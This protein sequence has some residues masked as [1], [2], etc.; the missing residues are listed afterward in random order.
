MRCKFW[1]SLITYLLI[2]GNCNLQKLAWKRLKLHKKQPL[3]WLLSLLI[4]DTRGVFHH[5]VA[6]QSTLW[7]WWSCFKGESISGY[8]YLGRLH[9][10]SN[11]GKRKR[12]IY[13][14]VKLELIA[15]N[16]VAI[17]QSWH[18]RHVSL[19]IFPFYFFELFWFWLITHCSAAGFLTW[20]YIKLY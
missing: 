2:E 10:F 4:R 14:L 18:D 20:R 19:L 5:H 17:K 15:F 16:Y 8:S 6:P 3:S 1:I 9:I 7:L 11:P 13:L 12:T